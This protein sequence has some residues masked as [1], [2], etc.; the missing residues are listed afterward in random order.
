MSQHRRTTTDPVLTAALDLLDHVD[1]YLVD[2]D[3]K[4]SADM[5]VVGAREALDAAVALIRSKATRTEHIVR[6]ED[7]Q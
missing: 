5:D 3:A 2:R 6:R 7:D 4:D 1:D